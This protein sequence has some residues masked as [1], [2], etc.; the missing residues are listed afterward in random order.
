MCDVFILV[1]IF[2]VFDTVAWDFCTIHIFISNSFHWIVYMISSYYQYYYFTI[3]YFIHAVL[4]LIHYLVSYLWHCSV[5]SGISCPALSASL[6]Y[7]DSYR[8]AHSPA[9]LTQAQRDFFGA[10]TYNRTDREG[11]FHTLWTEANSAAK[12]T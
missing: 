8:R 9:N 11:V 2:F 5:A 1:S 7:Y 3:F 4:L 6:A 10:H 12:K